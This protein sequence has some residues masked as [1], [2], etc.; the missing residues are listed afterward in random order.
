MND[1]WKIVTHAAG[2]RWPVHRWHGTS[3][4]ARAHYARLITVPNRG[5]ALINPDGH[6][7]K[8]HRR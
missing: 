2:D 1:R 5:V 3:D 4:A 8:E 6:V 7:V